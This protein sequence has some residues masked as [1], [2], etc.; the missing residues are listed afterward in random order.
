M[1]SHGCLM[2]M[3]PKTKNKAPTVMIFPAESERLTELNVVMTV[4]C[5]VLQKTDDVIT[6]AAV[7][8]NMRSNVDEFLSR[9]KK[10]IRCMN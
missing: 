4:V 7:T 10:F 8:V 5:V 2:V 3:T 6:D 1:V 9:T